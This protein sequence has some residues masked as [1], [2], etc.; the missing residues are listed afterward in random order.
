MCG[1]FV[2]MALGR[3][4][5]EL[6]ELEEEPLLEPRYNIAP[7]QPVAVVRLAADR[8]TR[9]LATLRWG[10]IP[11]WAKDTKIGYKMINAKSETIAEKPAFRVAFKH[12]RCLIPADGFYE[13]KKR[14]D[15]KQPYLVRMKDSLP[16]AFAG[17]WEHWDGKDGEVIQSCIILTTDANDLVMEIHDRMP[18]ILHPKDYRIWLDITLSDPEKLLNL[19]KPYPADEMTAYPVN[20]VVNKPSEE[21][22]KCVEPAASP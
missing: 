1:R 16:F 20:P 3:M 8:V 2:L 19:L 10:L 13:W 15:S 4:V 6:F 21:G 22:P 5:A 18:V 9:E 14:K 12:R 17:L 7:T 11:F